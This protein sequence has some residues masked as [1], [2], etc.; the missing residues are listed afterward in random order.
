[1]IIVFADYLIT[2]ALMSQKLHQAYFFRLIFRF[3]VLT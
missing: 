1:M 3:F 2:A